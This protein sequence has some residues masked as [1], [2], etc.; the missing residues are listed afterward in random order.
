MHLY[1]AYQSVLACREALWEELNDRLRNR[2]DELKPFG[3]EDEEDWEELQT[4]RKFE[5]LI[6]RYER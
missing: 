1:R 4:R 6:E 5:I 3:W 2:K